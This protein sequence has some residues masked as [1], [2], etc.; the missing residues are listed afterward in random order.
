MSRVLELSDEEY[1]RL[2]QAARE[3]GSTIAELVHRWISGM[4]AAPSEQSIVEA[5]KRWAMLNSFV[6]Q[7]TQDE[8]RAHPLLRASGIFQSSDPDLAARHDDIIAE[9]AL[10]S[11]ADE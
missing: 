8:L 9:E 3:H 2:E 10:D 7:P 1:A 11:H 5:Q 6:A 4:A